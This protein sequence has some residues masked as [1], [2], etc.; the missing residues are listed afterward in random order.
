MNWE[1]LDEENYTLIKKNR[2]KSDKRETVIYR[3]IV[4]DNNNKII[5]GY[6][7]Q[8]TN[9][10]LRIYDYTRE[11]K[12][13]YK[14][15]YITDYKVAGKIKNA[16]DDNNKTVILERLKIQDADIKKMSDKKYRLEL[17]RK[18]IINFIRLKDKPE[19]WNS[20]S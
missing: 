16:K 10:G 2:N 5:G 18:E 20:L 7:G 9:F 8:T 13:K 3:W 1:T 6:I 17:E 19:I 4:K 15:I 11:Y 12:P 14:K